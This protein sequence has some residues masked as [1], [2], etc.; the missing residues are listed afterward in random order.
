LTL[1]KTKAGKKAESLTNNRVHP[2]KRALFFSCNTQY[3]AMHYSHRCF[4]KGI[5]MKNTWQKQSPYVIHMLH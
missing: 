2:E 3:S 1:T 4:K 5:R